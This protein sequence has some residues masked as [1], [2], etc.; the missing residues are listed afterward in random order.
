MFSIDKKL[1]SCKFI[2]VLRLI[3]I[4]FLHDTFDR[5]NLVFFQFV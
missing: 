4:L 3:N 5:L 2:K 1:S